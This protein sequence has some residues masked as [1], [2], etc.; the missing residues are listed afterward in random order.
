MAR[1]DD[2]TADLFLEVPRPAA[3]LPGAMDYRGL[4]CEL[5]A[6][7]LDESGFEDRFLAAAAISRLAGK[8]VSKYMLDAYTSPAREEY[9]APAWLIPVIEAACR[10][11]LYTAWIADVRGGR[12]YL[13]AEALKAELGRM[14]HARD[15]IAKQIRDMKRRLGESE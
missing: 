3:P 11:H 6:R 10:S 2:R 1:R 15:E 4:V 14:E 13:G 8:E 12:L 5:I 7:M 9:N